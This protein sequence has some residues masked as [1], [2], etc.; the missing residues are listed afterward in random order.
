MHIIGENQQNIY[1]KPNFSG[2]NV[3]SPEGGREYQQIGIPD[4]QPIMPVGPPQGSRRAQTLL[5]L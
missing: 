3:L 1:Q 2:V 4:K 5:I